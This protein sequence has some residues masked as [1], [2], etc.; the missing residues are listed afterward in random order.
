MGKDTSSGMSLAR[1]S[2]L[3]AKGDTILDEFVKQ[4]A[5]ILQVRSALLV[6]KGWHS[7]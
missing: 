4:T 3:D 2:V 7:S 5:T 6:V 1:V